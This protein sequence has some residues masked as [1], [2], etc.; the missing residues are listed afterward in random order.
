MLDLADFQVNFFSELLVVLAVWLVAVGG[1][2]VEHLLDQEAALVDDGHALSEVAM[3]IGV[4]DVLSTGVPE[5]PHELEEV[6]AC[7]RMSDDFRELFAR[8]LDSSELR[9][10]GIVDQVQDDRR[11]QAEPLQHL[12]FVVDC[13]LFQAQQE[14]L[15]QLSVGLGIGGW[16]F[17]LGSW[18]RCQGPTADDFADGVGDPLGDS[19]GLEVLVCHCLDC[20]GRVEPVF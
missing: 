10:L 13:L 16:G 14:T 9:L 6:D 15:R 11:K 19:E 18:A 17:G 7:L 4:H 5:E 8:P 2:G 12:G 20:F 3:V 1:I